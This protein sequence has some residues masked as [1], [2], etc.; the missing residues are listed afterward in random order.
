MLCSGQDR[1]NERAEGIWTRVDRARVRVRGACFPAAVPSIPRRGIPRLRSPRRLEKIRAQYW[2]SE[3][4][5]KRAADFRGF[6]PIPRGPQMRESLTA[7]GVDIDRARLENPASRRAHEF[8]QVDAGGGSSVELEIRGL[9]SIATLH[10]IATSW[11]RAA[12]IH[13]WGS[14][15]GRGCRDNPKESIAM[16]GAYQSS[17]NRAVLDDG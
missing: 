3:G 17:L 14:S 10:L 15:I 12:H 1:D 8:V 2:V 5:S 16:D 11:K 7:N 4:E 9:V 6:A 13:P